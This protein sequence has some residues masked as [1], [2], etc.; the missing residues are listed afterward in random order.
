ML[1]QAMSKIKHL[2]Q[3]T[4]TS[5]LSDMEVPLNSFPSDKTKH[6]DYVIYYKDNSEKEVIKKRIA[7]KSLLENEEFKI[8]HLQD[9]RNKRN[10]WLL[11][12]S[13]E[14]L[15]NQAERMKLEYP[16]KVNSL[17]NFQIR[18]SRLIFLTAL[19]EFSKL[20]TES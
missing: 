14:R 18:G 2:S 8:E 12:C 5:C 20:F 16:L 7:F 4:E 6:I 19:D 9:K 11:N 17:N 1:F 13:L 15:M 10:F 3:I